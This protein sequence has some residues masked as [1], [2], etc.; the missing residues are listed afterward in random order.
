MGSAT[1]QQ[2][3]RASP[4]SIRPETHCQ[5][6]GGC[7]PLEHAQ[8]QGYEICPKIRLRKLS[9]FLLIRARIRNF[10]VF[11]LKAHVVDMSENKGMG[12]SLRFQSRA[13]GE[14]I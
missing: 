2:M 3:N 13:P 5:T 1:H 10:P 12:H 11:P 6:E 14:Q 4:P 7:R 8:R 9:V